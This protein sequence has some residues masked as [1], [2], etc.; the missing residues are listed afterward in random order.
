MADRGPIYRLDSRVEK[1]LE[2]LG[3]AA[4]EEGLSVLDDLVRLEAASLRASPSGAVLSY[5]DG[6]PL[7]DPAGRAVVAALVEGRDH[8]GVDHHA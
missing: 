1:L 5:L 2:G 4:R 3:A 8:R 7:F 6:W